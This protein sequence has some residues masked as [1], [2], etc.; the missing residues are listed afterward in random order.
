MPAQLN[1]NAAVPRGEKAFRAWIGSPLGRMLL[2]ADTHGLTGLYFTDQPDC[3][4]E[5]G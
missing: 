1:R 3:P 4:P 5:A 2:C